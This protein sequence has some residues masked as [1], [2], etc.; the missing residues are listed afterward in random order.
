VTAGVAV[1]ADTER[2]YVA[3]FLANTVSVINAATKSVS[4]TIAEWIEQRV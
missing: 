4:A 1:S 3:N 2:V